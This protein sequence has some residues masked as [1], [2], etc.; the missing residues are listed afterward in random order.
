MTDIQ[1]RISNVSRAFESEGT[2]VHALDD[3]TLSIRRGEFIS[4]LGP[5]GCGKT[6]LLRMLAGLDHPDTGIIAIDGAPITGPSL[7]RGI[8]FQDHRLFPW[9]GVRGNILLAL[10]KSPL[11]RDGRSKASQDLIDLVG[12][13]G[14]EDARPHQ[15][16]GGMA[17]R[18]AIAR[19]LA[20]RPDI[21]LL[22]EPLGALDSL[23][24]TRLQG[25]LLRIWK[26]EGSTMV[27][28]THDIDEA[29]TLS[30]RIVVMEPRPGRIKTV[31]DVDL[32]HPRDRSNRE[33]QAIHSRI[34][35][36]FHEKLAA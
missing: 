30:D 16:S 36:E 6:T 7:K 17:Q 11:D 9:L 33:Y 24:R 35:A 27:M 31:V 15:L 8:V 29:I 34:L 23:T 14:F 32:D 26:H 2:P 10:H 25:E 22:D 3:V 20:P 5:S 19:S 18:A 1:I 13:R 28:V 4:L 12:L 21:L